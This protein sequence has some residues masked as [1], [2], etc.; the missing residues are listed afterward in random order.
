LGRSLLLAFANSGYRILGTY[1]RDHKAADDLRRHLEGHGN[2]VR[3]F[4]WEFRKAEDPP[5][6]FLAALQM[7]DATTCVFIHCAGMPFLPKSFH[8]TSWEEALDQLKVAVGGAWRIVQLVLP[9]MV[10][11]NGGTIAFVLTSAMPEVSKPVSKGL[12]SYLA[13]KHALA[14]LARAL[15]VEYAGRGVR[16]MTFSPKFMDTPLTRSWPESLRV[17]ASREGTQDPDDY[18]KYML[19]CVQDLALQRPAPGL[20]IML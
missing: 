15:A 4:A 16:V 11:A 8:M 13:A 6:E 5:P 1:A 14:G 18:A 7:I 10:R 2:S 12:S 20:P 17:S 3:L 19:R 9:A